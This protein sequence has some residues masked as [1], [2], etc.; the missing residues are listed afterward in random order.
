MSGWLVQKQTLKLD[1][2]TQTLY[3]CLVFW[4][5]LFL[6][7]KSYGARLSDKL[8]P[9]LSPYYGLSRYSNQRLTFLADFAFA[10]NWFSTLPLCLIAHVILNCS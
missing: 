4:A 8:N 6:Q 5:W 7:A 1:L 2:G 9:A 3:A 10:S